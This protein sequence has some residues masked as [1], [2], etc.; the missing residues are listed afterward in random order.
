MSSNVLSVT[1]YL[2]NA[3]QT[4]LSPTVS[5]WEE[6]GTQ[7]V[8]AASMTEDS[9][10]SGKYEYSF[11][12][13]NVT[14]QY[15]GRFDAGTDTIDLRYYDFVLE[16]Y[17]TNQ[18]VIENVPR[19]GG[20][21][22]T[23]NVERKFTKEQIKEIVNKLIEKVEERTLNID[24]NIDESIINAAYSDLKDQAVQSTQKVEKAATE[25]IKGINKKVS[26]PEVKVSTQEVRVETI[27]K[28]LLK[29]AV[30]EVI[31]KAHDQ[32][33][34]MSAVEDLLV[35]QLSEQEKMLVEVLEE[36]TQ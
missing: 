20:G 19:G 9:N 18:D 16:P 29:A 25:Q 8:N 36:V 28:A 7:V 15:E 31:E 23:K 26:K 27:D 30:K 11:T 21:G 32:K 22:V 2:N 12:S 5:I 14:K 6:N 1:F 34:L 24:V 13:R 33:G 10:M 3:P 17:A 4:G 35:K